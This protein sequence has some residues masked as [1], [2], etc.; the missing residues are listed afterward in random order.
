M[1]VGISRVRLYLLPKL[2]ALARN[3][4]LK[5]PF[6]TASEESL[7]LLFGEMSLGCKLVFL[8]LPDIT[9]FEEEF[10]VKS[11]KVLKDGEMDV[12][13]TLTIAVREGDVLEHNGEM[14]GGIKGR[15]TSFCL[16]PK[17][18]RQAIEKGAIEQIS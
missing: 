6:I 13:S 18:L 8:A 14:F 9:V 11:F 10:E 1:I 5:D 7:F 4:G 2:L 12:S 17:F 3:F 16:R 15:N